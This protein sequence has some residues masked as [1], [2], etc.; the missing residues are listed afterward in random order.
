MK[1]LVLQAAVAA[2]LIGAGWI[3]A[4]AQQSTPDFE[5]IVDAPAGPTTIK[6]VRGCSLMWLE[7]GINPNDRPMQTFEF[8]CTGSQIGPRCSSAKVGGWVT[9]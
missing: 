1:R 7:R 8:A 9:Q 4:R 6:C 2:A 3:A 5:I